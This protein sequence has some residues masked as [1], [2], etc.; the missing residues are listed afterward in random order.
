MARAANSRSPANPERSPSLGVKL[1]LRWPSKNRLRGLVLTPLLLA[2]VAAHGATT[3]AVF[4][5]WSGLQL[6]GALIF[7]LAIF[8]VL[9][10]VLKRFQPGVTGSSSAILRVVATLPLGTRERLLLVDLQ[11]Q[12]LL[13]GISPAGISLLHVLEQPLTPPQR[14]LPTD[15]SGWLRQAMERRR[16]G[17]WHETPVC[18]P[19]AAARRGDSS[20]PPSAD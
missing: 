7:V 10:W 15:F 12:Q 5:W 19:T 16:K 18:E 6:V 14:N 20:A 4:S 8:L 1:S 2:S 9:V 11:G 3:E 17:T 13:L